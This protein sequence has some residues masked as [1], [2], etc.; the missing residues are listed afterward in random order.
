VSEPG[1]IPGERGARV[2]LEGV[3]VV[4]GASAGIGM[5]VARAL[6][7]RGRRV[8]VAARRV[9]ILE[10]LAGEIDG[11]AVACDVT[12]WEQVKALVDT[13]VE[14]GGRLDVL[15]NNAGFGAFGELHELDPARTALMVQ[16]NITGVIY[17]MRAAGE[18]MARQGRGGIVN[19]SS[20]VGEF[21][22]PGGGAYAASKAAVDLL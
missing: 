2:S 14:W 22:D 9:E 16:T 7:E 12:S 8:V 1:D 13:A 15:V 11:L 3:A 4:T 5:A 6:D 18:I 10:E 17:G 21:P 20:I 19:I